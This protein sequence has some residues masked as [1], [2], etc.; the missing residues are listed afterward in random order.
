MLDIRGITARSKDV[1]EERKGP[2]TDAPEKA[3]ECNC[4]HCRIKGMLLAFFPVDRFHLDQGEDAL[5][6]YRFNTHKI[7]HQ[8]CRT[9]GTQPMA[10]GAL[11]DGTLSRGINLRCVPEADLDTLKRIPHDGASR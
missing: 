3:I 4:S 9:C 11:P 10:L 6:S 8:F 7:E 5:Q 1:R 2:R